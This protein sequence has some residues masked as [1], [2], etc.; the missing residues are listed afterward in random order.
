MKKLLI[1]GTGGQGKVVLDCA[2]SQGAYADIAFLTNDMQASQIA[3]YPVYY[4]QDV[5]SSSQQTGDIPLAFLKKFDEA[6]IAI[7]NNEVRLKKSRQFLDNGVELATLRT[8]IQK[9]TN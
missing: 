8:C 9:A 6:I 3:G 4:E 5:V 2:L 7:G 1:V